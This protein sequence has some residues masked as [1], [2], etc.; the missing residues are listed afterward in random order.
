MSLVTIPKR[1]TQELDNFEAILRMMNGLL[2]ESNFA[3]GQIYSASK[4][5]QSSW[6]AFTPILTAT[7]SNPTLG[8][9]GGGGAF[10][11]YTRQADRLIVA[12]YFVQFGTSGMAVGAGN[13]KLSLPVS[14]EGASFGVG[15]ASDVSA[16]GAYMLEAIG[17]SADTFLMW[18][19]AIEPSA[20]ITDAAP[21]TWGAGDV[22]F[23][24]MVTYDADE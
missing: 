19:P 21:I 14:A 6:T 12:R 22:I 4:F 20:P 5:K 16:G 24:G 13:Y 15:H 3:G 9:G 8:T 17:D 18:R 7:G 1:E 11:V 23:S 2:D 10:G